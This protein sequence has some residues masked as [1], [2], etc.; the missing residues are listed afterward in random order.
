MEAVKIRM[1]QFVFR[2]AAGKFFRRMGK[3]QFEGV[4]VS[5]TRVEF[6]S[7]DLEVNEE[8]VNAEVLQQSQVRLVSGFVNSM[9]GDF[10]VRTDATRRVVLDGVHLTLDFI[11]TTTTTGSSAAGGKTDPTKTGPSE[12]SLGSIGRIVSAEDFFSSM[13][14]DTKQVKGNASP[15]PSRDD[16][17]DDDDRMPADI[18][19]CAAALSNTVKALLHNTIGILRDVNIRMRFPPPGVDIVPGKPLPKDSVEVLIH[20]PK[21]D[22]TDATDVAKALNNSFRKRIRFSGIMVQVY[23]AAN[24]VVRDDDAT[25]TQE[26]DLS[27]TVLQGDPINLGA[28]EASPTLD[29]VAALAERTARDRTTARVGGGESPAP[30]GE[31]CLNELDVELNEAD[32]ARPVWRKKLSITQV[33][34]VLAP[35]Q[36]LRVLRVVE[37]FGRTPEGAQK[38]GDGHDAGGS[39]GGGADRDGAADDAGESK[40]RVVLSDVSLS[41]LHNDDPHGVSDVW[42]RFNSEHQD[43][44][45]TLSQWPHYAVRLSHFLLQAATPLEYSHPDPAEPDPLLH[46][47]NRVRGSDLTIAVSAATVTERQPAAATTTVVLRL[48]EPPPDVGKS[49][50]MCRR[51]S[52]PMSVEKAR[53]YQVDVDTLLGR[54]AA[55]NKLDL[56]DLQRSPMTRISQQHVLFFLGTPLQISADVE[57]LDR[58]L[59]FAKRLG[60]LSTLA[61]THF[62]DTGAG[63]GGLPVLPSPSD[64]SRKKQTLESA[65]SNGNMFYSAVSQLNSSNDSIDLEHLGD[66]VQ[67]T[68]THMTSSSSSDGDLCDTDEEAQGG[69]PKRRPLGDSTRSHSQKGPYGSTATHQHPHPTAPTGLPRFPADTNRD[70]S[71]MFEEGNASPLQLGPHTIVASAVAVKCQ[72]VRILLKFPVARPPPPDLYGPDSV[73]LFTSL[74]KH[75]VGPD[76]FLDAPSGRAA[77]N[78]PAAAPNPAHNSP[79]LF[80]PRS[81]MLRC[82]GVNIDL[83]EGTPAD[84][85]IAADTIMATFRQLDTGS[86][87]ALLAA[88]ALPSTQTAHVNFAHGESGAAQ[89]R[90]PWNRGRGSYVESVW[91]PSENHGADHSHSP[92]AGAVAPTARSS[93]HRGGAPLGGHGL[94]AERPGRQRVSSRGR[95]DTASI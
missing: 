10:P 25:I 64:A 90:T 8:T 4:R 77:A 95:A 61:K 54:Y 63:G 75:A 68:E 30:E 1:V 57:M 23:D 28:N 44:A 67:H 56:R 58:V 70:Q 80:L 72:S 82:D 93:G 19:E 89:P 59:C 39:A 62:V 87:V 7:T 14:E 66:M 5:T 3:D 81:L 41:L 52:F 17:D 9:I 34:A 48:A 16:D 86:E 42:R 69:A 83:P 84:M 13:V 15:P 94:R 27:N 50:V 11:G 20:I 85:V 51:S 55:D 53:H 45:V 79:L 74:A 26:L 76:A 18:D 88:T 21:I 33:H 38:G 71:I 40:L 49:M 35:G 65:A 12:R 36:L 60:D 2:S 46:L 78:P 32:P 37:Y 6:T 24:R 47:F 73:R 22:V 43:P 92:G 29:D 91:S 31:S